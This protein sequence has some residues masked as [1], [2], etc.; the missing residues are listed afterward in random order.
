MDRRK[1]L[2]GLIAAVAIPMSARVARVLAPAFPVTAARFETYT[3]HFAWNMG[4]AVEDWRYVTRVADIDTSEMRDIFSAM[5][6]LQHH[7]VPVHA[8]ESLNG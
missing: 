7:G 8:V 1:F 6:G 3:S 5:R 2:R 4:I